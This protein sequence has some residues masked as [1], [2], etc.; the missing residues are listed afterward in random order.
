MFH[1]NRLQ[2]QQLCCICVVVLLRPNYS[3]LSGA[4]IRQDLAVTGWGLRRIVAVE[5]RP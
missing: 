4:A 5:A 1:N 2:I 3:P